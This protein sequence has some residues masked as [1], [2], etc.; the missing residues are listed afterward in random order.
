MQTA[1]DY[2]ACFELGRAI[3]GVDVNCHEV[4]SNAEVED[5][6]SGLNFCR[7]SVQA[8][9]EVGVKLVAQS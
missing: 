2:L 4:K 6:S 1:V 3:Q 8:F 9:T 5:E 7:H